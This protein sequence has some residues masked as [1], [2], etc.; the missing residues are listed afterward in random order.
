[1]RNNVS[2]LFKNIHP[3][4][5]QLIC[6]AFSTG[7]FS[8]IL[9]NRSPNFLRPLSMSLRTGFGLVIPAATLIVYLA[10]R[11][12]GRLGQ[13]VGM[14]T[15]LSLFAMP[16]AGL[17]ASGLTQSIVISGIV[18]LSDAVNYYIDGL[19][20]MASSN[21]SHFSAMRPI[22]PGFLSLLLA[23]TNQ[24][25]MV[26]LAI[27]TAVAA[28]AFYF[29]AREIQRTHGAEAAT[30]ILIFM[31]LYFRAHSGTSMSESLGVAI[32]ALGI[33]LIWRGLEKH[34]QAITIFGL[35]I[36]ALALNIRPGAMFILPF[37]LVWTSWAFKNRGEFISKRV[38]LLGAGVIVIGFAVNFLLIK[39][40]SDPSG[41]AFSNFSWA[42]YGLASGGN[43]YAYVFQVHPELKQLHDPQQSRAIYK[44]ALDIIVQNPSLIIKGSFYYWSK[45]FSNTWYNA[46]SFISGENA[47]VNTIARWGIYVL[48]A[49]GIVK[50]VQKPGDL[51]NGLAVFAA[52]GV[53]V[54]VPFVPPTD[55]YRVR[56]YAATIIAFGLL[57]C[58]GIV[59][60]VNYLK[61]HLNIFSEPDSNL[62]ETNETIVYSGLLI[63]IILLAPILIKLTSQPP[64]IM[65]FSC[66]SGMSKVM[67][68]FDN[69]TSINI[70]RENV[71]ALDWA[72]TFHQG[73]FKRN[74]HGLA[75][76]NLMDYF[77]TREPPFSI[78]YSLDYL[79]NEEALI[80][81]PTNLLPAPNS[82]I[83]VCGHWEEN[84]DIKAYNIF[85]A[86]QIVKYLPK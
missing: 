18:P 85:N 10:F 24:N 2:T 86:E 54:S 26:S 36:T 34:S 17:W 55:G 71:F 39:L 37:L 41:T 63:S 20:I 47:T 80:V 72:P 81:V 46:F 3:I 67:A 9:L 40:L 83:G 61:T 28:F 32:G 38:F 23:V 79:S 51:H 62:Q 25:L 1:M 59:L 7:I 42:V 33:G 70:T 50:W 76:N 48:S 60:I 49:L 69:G 22:F 4:L 84:P 21:I 8:L 5:W 58:M 16:L 43:S 13:L 30:F 53:L 78:F 65:S 82:Y 44:L 74:I 19:R 27:I 12:K 31:F 6:F 73:L 11:V 14:A 75:D 66:P 68:R 77:G 57:P 64:Q 35:F 56:L 52:I 45:F 29:S 15:T